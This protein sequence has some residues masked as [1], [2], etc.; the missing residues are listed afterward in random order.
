[1]I[2]RIYIPPWRLTVQD[3]QKKKEKG[4]DVRIALK[5]RKRNHNERFFFWNCNG[6]G[7]AKKFKFLT[8]L[9]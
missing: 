7:G 5:K 6:L 2:W 9:I 4:K 3:I 1:M 8:A